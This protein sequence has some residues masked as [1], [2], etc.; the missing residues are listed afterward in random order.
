MEKIKVLI[1]ENELLI[2]QDLKA[3]LEEHQ[4]EVTAIH[5]SG[6]D[7]LTEIDINMPD[8]ILMDIHLDGDL[9]GIETTEQITRRYDIPVIYLSDHVDKHTVDRA[10]HTFPANYLS[11]PYKSSDLLRALELAFINAK[12]QNSRNRPSK[13]SDRIFIRTDNQAVEM[14]RYSDILYLEAER[15]YCCVVTD[16]AKHVLSSNMRKVFDQ[17]ES[18]DFIKV[19]RSFIINI[20]RI[21]GIEGNL[22]KLG[23]KYT[24]QMSSKYKDALIGKIHTVK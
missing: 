9:D 7:A 2:A 5:T 23:D 11:K 10:K 1:V 6:E 17:F 8:L 24:V 14:I 13:L 19:H 18:P 15:A 12:R 20:N 16:K 4:F 22:I 21:T 3:R